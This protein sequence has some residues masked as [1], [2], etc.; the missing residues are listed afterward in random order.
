MENK[1][2]LERLK[3]HLKNLDVDGCVID[4][5]T[6]LFYLLGI[7]LSLGRMIITQHDAALFVDGRYFLECQERSIVPTMPLEEEQISAFLLKEK[8]SRL[9]FDADNTLYRSYENLEKMIQKTGLKIT[10]VSCDHFLKEI[11]VIKDTHE[12][13]CLKRSADLLWKGFQHIQKILKEGITE[14]QV[15]LEFELFVRKNGADELSF[16]PI[17]AF[18][19]NGAKPHHRSSDLKLKKNDT[20]LID[21]GV[22]VNHYCSDMTRVVFINEGNPDVKRLYSINRKAQKAALAR[23]KP[24]AFLKDLDL[25]AREEMKKEK[26]EELFV[27]SLGHGVGLDIHEFPRV[28]SKGLEQN[29]LLKPGMV[30]TIEPG[31]YLPHVGGVRYEDTILITE[32]GYLNFYPHEI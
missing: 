16:T 15:A 11:R 23:C 1:K 19:E 8:V 29:V 3:L 13:D 32:E 5:P 26:V 9:G 24:G 27:H 14:K 30:I 4:H 6:D 2:R 28:S 25:A 21:I 31:L 20:A 10:L 22:K 12:I 7:E 18:G 17:I